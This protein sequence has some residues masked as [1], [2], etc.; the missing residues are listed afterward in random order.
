MENHRAFSIA[1]GFPQKNLL[2]VSVVSDKMVLLYILNKN[3]RL[4][5]EL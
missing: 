5:F 1:I 4:K 2:C 3:K